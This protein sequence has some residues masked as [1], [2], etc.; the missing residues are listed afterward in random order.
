MRAYLTSTIRSSRSP[1]AH[2]ALAL[3]DLDSGKIICQRGMFPTPFCARN[4]NPRG[5]S[6]GWRGLVRTEVSVIAA[7]NDG[8]V[9]WDPDLEQVSK[10]VT[11]P[12]LANVH[13]LSVDGSNLLVAST[14]NDAWAIVSAQGDFQFTSILGPMSPAREIAERQG[15]VQYGRELL[16]ADHDYREVWLDDVC[17][18]NYV[19]RLSTGRLVAF[20]A[21]FDAVIEI[22]PEPQVIW[23]PREGSGYIAAVRD[24]KSFDRRSGLSAPHDMFELEPDVVAINSSAGRSL[25]ILDCGTGALDELWASGRLDRAWHRGL[26]VDDGLAYIGTGRGSVIVVDLDAGKEIDEIPLLAAADPDQ[27]HAVFSVVL[28]R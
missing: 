20:I 8:I 7:N 18:L 12:W 17:H 2:G 15:A 21:R 19:Q 10:I 1:T 3:C 9:Y 22:E 27:A 6:R 13:G 28:E 26:A 24:G 5:G 23:A 4:P 25:H 14:L 11:H 16:Q